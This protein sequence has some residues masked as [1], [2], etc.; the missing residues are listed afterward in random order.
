MS[1]VY[2]QTAAGGWEILFGVLKW[3]FLGGFLGLESLTLVSFSFFFFPLSE[4]F[5]E[6]GCLM[7]G[8]VWME[9]AEISIVGCYGRVSRILGSQRYA[10]GE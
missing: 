9:R 1:D 10:R 8:T 4:F 3:G 7:L 5:G 2:F 6:G